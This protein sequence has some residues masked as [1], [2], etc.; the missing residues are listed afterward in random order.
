MLG[1]IMK[2]I[3][4]PD[5]RRLATA[6]GLTLIVVD[7][8]VAWMTG[9]EAWLAGAAGGAA[10]IFAA[11][12]CDT[13]DG[14]V[15]TLARQA[16]EQRNVNLVLPWVREVDEPEIRAA[17]EHATAVRDLGGKARDLADHHFFETLVRIH[18]AGEGVPYTGLRPAGRDLGPAIPAAD[19]ALQSGSIDR[20]LH[21]FNDAVLDG[22]HEHFHRAF[23]R[24]R[25]E[26]ND[27]KAGRRYVEAYVSYMHYV[28][29]LWAAATAPA[30][31]HHGELPV[32]AAVVAEV[33]R[34]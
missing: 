10:L 3:A 16:F 8:L 32:H 34:H 24:K 5:R 6:I 9:T 17:F 7:R 15:V 29:R 21:F 2:R 22:L 30:H 11:G 23:D 26:T 27:V 31:G 14:P 18:R 1:G 12:H 19:R 4:L 13:L 20:L 28:E 25:Y 33:H